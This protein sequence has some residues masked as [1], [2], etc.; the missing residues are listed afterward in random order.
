MTCVYCG[1]Q[2]RR[3][4]LTCSKHSDLPAL[5]P[6][7]KTKEQKWAEGIFPSLP[8]DLILALRQL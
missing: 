6:R 8:E 2:I 7:W 4:F 1:Q 5:D 3:D